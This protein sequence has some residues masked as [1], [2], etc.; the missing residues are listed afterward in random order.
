[1]AESY[2]GILE[3]NWKRGELKISENSGF[4]QELA[5]GQRSGYL[6][7]GYP[8]SKTT[9]EELMVTKAGEVF[10][11]RNL[12]NVVRTLYMNSI[13]VIQYCVKYSN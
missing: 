11:L 4:L 2:A 6:Y 8:D 13:T 5:K 9:A 1:M 7:I 10:T 3:N 12:A